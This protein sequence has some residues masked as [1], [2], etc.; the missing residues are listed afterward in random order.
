MILSRRNV[1]ILA[2]HPDD[3]E[4]SMGCTVMQLVRSGARVQYVAFSPCTE[5][6]PDGYEP[7]AI[8]SEFAASCLRMGVHW[9]LF[10]LPVRRLCDH[11]QDILEDMIKIRDTIRP[12]LVFIPS[13][14][15]VH[16]DH[17]TIHNEGVRAFKNT[18]LVGYDLPWNHLSDHSTL[19]V[20]TTAE[21]V[22]AKIDLIST[23]Q[24]QAGR[25]YS[26]P[27]FIEAMAR[28]K[29]TTVG[30]EY[31]ESFEVIRWIC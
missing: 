19:Y 1:L 3:T 13:T 5:S 14:G 16:Q 20:P 23:Y 2:A 6:V 8:A 12:D 27:A 28:V 30:R 11:R 17:A 7:D 24:T 9:S 26:A 22:E 21:E 15:D 4:Y 31:A 25:S 10:K 29:G 18:S